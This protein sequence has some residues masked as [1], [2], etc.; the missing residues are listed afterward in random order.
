MESLIFNLGSIGDVIIRYSLSGCKVA[1][2]QTAKRNLPGQTSV[3]ELIHYGQGRSLQYPTRLVRC[4]HANALCSR[5]FY[6]GLS[7]H[8]QK[9]SCSMW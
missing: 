1:F 2:E 8:R 3:Y 9:K 5:K 4:A 6:V 7:Q